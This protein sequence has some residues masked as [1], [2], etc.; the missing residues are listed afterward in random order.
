VFPGE[1]KLLIVAGDP[2][3]DLHA[4][5]LVSAIKARA[6]EARVLAAGGPRMRQAGA[7]MVASLDELGVMGFAEV[8]SKLPQFL[9][10]MRHM[11]RVLQQEHPQLVIAVDFP[12]FNLRLCREAKRAG[13]RVMYYIAPQAWAWG[14]GR[15]KLM[16]SVIDRLAVVFPFEVGFFRAAGIDTEFVGHPLLESVGVKE[17]KAA[18]RRRLGVAP[19]SRVVALL[20]G[21]RLQEVRRLLPSMLEVG[22]L[23]RSECGVEVA[24]GAADSVPREEFD[25][26]VRAAAARSGPEAPFEPRVFRGVTSDLLAAAD[27]AVIA[28]GSATLEAAIVGTPMVIVYRVS[29]VSWAIAKRIVSID[30]IGLVNIVA[31]EKI[32]SEYLQD[33]I[34][35]RRMA[36]EVRELV[37]NDRKRSEVISR[38]AQVRSLLGEPGASEKAAAMALGMVGL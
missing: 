36:E 33:A 4:S 11:K 2:S 14:R 26:A 34:D 15:L 12:G 20:P 5:R 6:P 32:V 28:S 3:G 24:V 18:G 19:E 23:L 22:R 25:G 13:A 29:P 31:G 1:P 9:L 16:A 35:P 38:L 7:E 37:F 17:D 8:L 21:S 10:L 30:T 27:A